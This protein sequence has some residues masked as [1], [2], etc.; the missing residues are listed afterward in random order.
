M[1]SLLYDLHT[2]KATKKA[3]KKTSAPKKTSLSTLEIAKWIVEQEMTKTKKKSL[4]K[5]QKSKVAVPLS[6]SV[7]KT[8]K[9][10]NKKN[11]KVEK[12]TL[13]KEE[14]PMEESFE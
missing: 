8:K 1:S 10:K 9:T 7:K 11:E 13:E 5:T 12:S 3:T 4:S 6:S 14:E 2:K